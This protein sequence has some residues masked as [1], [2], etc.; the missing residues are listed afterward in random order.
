MEKCRIVVC[1]GLQ[2]AL[3]CVSGPVL[4]FHC[5]S[6]GLVTKIG[7]KWENATKFFVL[8]WDYLQN[9]NTQNHT[10]HACQPNSMLEL[11]EF[12]TL[13]K[14]RHSWVGLDNLND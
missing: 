3:R 11:I 8:K 6:V 9:E 2:A 10:P 5:G 13:L 1:F 4:I 7:T 12:L 14:T